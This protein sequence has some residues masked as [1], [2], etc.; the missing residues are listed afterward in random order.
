MGLV[1]CPRA[2]KLATKRSAFS[3]SWPE[4]ASA[5][6]RLPKLLLIIAATLALGVAGLIESFNLLAAKHRDQVTQELQ[7]VFGQDVS[8]ASLE[9]NVFGRPG[10]V[11]KEFTIADDSRF[12]ATPALR[13]RE[14]EN[15][16]RPQW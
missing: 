15:E 7:K 1:C 13:A 3:Y 6:K 16:S 8:F 12:A 10:F 4:L 9:V 14:L 11:A 5:M 2:A